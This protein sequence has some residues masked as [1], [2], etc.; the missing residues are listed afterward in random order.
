MTITSILA[1][2]FRFRCWRALRF[3]KMAL[4]TWLDFFCLDFGSFL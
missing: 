4:E 1:S 2:D 3:P